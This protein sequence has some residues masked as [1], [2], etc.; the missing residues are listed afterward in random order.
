MPTFRPCITR[1]LPEEK[2]LAIL[3]RLCCL[4][5]LLKREPF[6]AHQWG[7]W[8]DRTISATA[9][10]TVLQMGGAVLQNSDMHMGACHALTL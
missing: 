5:L 1:L 7:A 6:T 3:L 9:S 8:G 10:D 2:P 4:N